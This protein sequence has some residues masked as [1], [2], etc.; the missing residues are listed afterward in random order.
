MWY[1]RLRELFAENTAASK[2]DVNHTVK[3]R[4]SLKISQCYR[5]CITL[6]KELN[7]TLNTC[8]NVVFD[9]SFKQQ[10]KW[11]LMCFVSCCALCKST[12]RAPLWWQLTD[13][14]TESHSSPLWAK[15]HFCGFP[16][17]QKPQTCQ[18]KPIMI[19]VSSCVFTCNYLK[20]VM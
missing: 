16:D 17:S 5:Y 15:C 10:N 14:D 13:R 20:L 1:N 8:Q 2:S 3:G 11:A 9:L 7:Q 12:P 18:R 6:L 19:T 4:K